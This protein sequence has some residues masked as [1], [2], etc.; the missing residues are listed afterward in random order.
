[1]FCVFLQSHFL[2][3]SSPPGLGKRLIDCLLP[4]NFVSIQIIILSINLV[5]MLNASL[6]LNL[7]IISDFLTEN[8][9]I[10]NPYL[11]PKSENL[12][13]HSS[14]SIENS[15]PSSGTSLLASCK[16]VPPPPPAHLLLWVLRSLAGLKSPHLSGQNKCV[17]CNFLVR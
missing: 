5:S 9:P 6:L 4:C 13:P 7:I 14:N 16:G 8:R 1:M 11:P 3:Y 12:Q 2:V 15:T 17:S 10:L